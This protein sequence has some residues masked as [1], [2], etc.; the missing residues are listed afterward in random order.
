MSLRKQETD[1]AV[2][3]LH[4]LLLNNWTLVTAPGGGKQWEAL[5]AKEEYPDPFIKGKFRRPT[6]LTSDLG[7]KADPIYN[8]ISTTFMHDFDYFTEKFALA[9]CKFLSYWPG[10]VN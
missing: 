3:F 10:A 5:D 4:S 9:W 8:N 7:L 1:F 2:D 6:M